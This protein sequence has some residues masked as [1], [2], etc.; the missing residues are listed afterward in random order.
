MAHKHYSKQFTLKICLSY[1]LGE[2]GWINDREFLRHQHQQGVVRMLRTF[3]NHFHCC[4]T[5][6]GVVLKY[7][8]ERAVPIFILTTAGGSKSLGK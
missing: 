7:V 3:R 4:V 2:R 6:H 1:W 5:L 8:Q